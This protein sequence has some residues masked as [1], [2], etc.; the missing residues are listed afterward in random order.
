MP[1]QCRDAKKIIDGDSTKPAR[2]PGWNRRDLRKNYLVHSYCA[3][4]NI[5]AVDGVDLFSVYLLFVYFGAPLSIA[6]TITW[7]IL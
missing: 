3:D 7:S 1:T 4:T 2:G 5:N 6:V